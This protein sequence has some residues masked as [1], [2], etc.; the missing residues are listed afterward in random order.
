MK[1]THNDNNIC[2]ASNGGIA[3]NK[4]SHLSF[5]VSFAANLHACSG[6]S[7]SSLF[8]LAALEQARN[9]TYHCCTCFVRPR[10]DKSG[11]TGPGLRG[12]AGT[13]IRGEL[14]A[15]SVQDHSCR[16][17][18]I[19]TDADRANVPKNRDSLVRGLEADRA[20]EI[21]EIDHIRA[22][23]RHSSGQAERQVRAVRP[24]LLHATVHNYKE[25]SVDRDTATRIQTLKQ[26]REGRKA[27]LPRPQVDLY[28]SP[29]RTAWSTVYGCVRQRG[30][31]QLETTSA[32]GWLN[33]A[34]QSS[35]GDLEA[36]D[37]LLCDLHKLLSVLHKF[38]LEFQFG[39]K[40]YSIRA[41]FIPEGRLR[42]QVVTVFSF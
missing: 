26:G 34:P 25:V 19:S 14:Q 35:G 40:F 18:K 38:G 11:Q 12:L 5:L 1:F 6:L 7:L 33:S 36:F 21:T 27:S 16:L 22:E 39:P 41:S 9:S 28:Q 8:E 23:N 31:K 3:A 24:L 20:V 32:A 10:R 29:H 4:S 2:F 30:P 13:Y 17:H 37:R 15:S 42:I